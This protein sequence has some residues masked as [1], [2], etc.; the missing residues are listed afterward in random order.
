MKLTLIESYLIQVIFNIDYF[1]SIYVY[2]YPI[3]LEVRWLNVYGN[4]VSQPNVFPI[5][6]SC[7]FSCEEEGLYSVCL[8]KY[9][10]RGNVS[11]HYCEHSH[12]HTQT[13]SRKHVCVIMSVACNK[14]PNNFPQLIPS[15][16][17]WHAWSLNEKYLPKVPCSELEL[18]TK[19]LESKFHNHTA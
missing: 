15:T 19:W 16:R 1:G 2:L 10:V 7:L 17:Y 5:A 12:K 11:K 9:R 6:N 3:L 13:Y 18:M 14:L 8:W 4:I